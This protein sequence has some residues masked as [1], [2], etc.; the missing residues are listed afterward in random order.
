MTLIKLNATRGLEGAL[1]AVSGANLTNIDGGKIAQVI[2][3]TSSTNSSTNSSSY[4]TWLSVNI[5]PSATSSK[6]LIFASSGR[7]DSGTSANVI[8]FTLFRDSTDLGNTDGGADGF[9][10]H[11]NESANAQGHFTINF[12]DSPNT[13]SQVTYTI[14]YKQNGGTGTVYANNSGKGSIQVLEVLA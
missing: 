12:L 7:N 11:R 14:Q 4:G 6:V 3:T 8:Q 10:T 1:P 2:Q 9:F 13:T 5:T